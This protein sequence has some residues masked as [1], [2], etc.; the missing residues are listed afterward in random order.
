MRVPQHCPEADYLDFVAS[1]AQF[2]RH[3]LNARRRFY[4]DFRQRWPSLAQWFMA[5]LA[6]RAGRLPGEGF[7][8]ASFPVSHRARP[9]LTFLGLRGHAAFDYPWMLAV[10]RLRV[11]EQAGLL[12]LDLG[13]DALVEEAVAM[14]YHQGSARQAMSWCV[15]RIVLRHG[16]PDAA[17]ITEA[18]IAEALDAIRCFAEHPQ[19]STFYT[20][21]QQFRDGPAK[22]WITH[23]HQLQVVLYHRGQ[24]ATQ[25]SKLMPSWKPPLVLPTLMLAAA[26]RWLAARRLTDA[27]ST[28]A[29]LELA[30]RTFGMWLADNHPEISTFAAVT[31]EHCLDWIGHLAETPSETTRKPLGVMSRIQRIS[32]M[33]QFF[34]DTAVWQ[35]PDVPGHTLVGAGDAPKF[36]Q[37]VPRFI[38]E[39]ELEQLMPVIDQ[40][41]CPFQRAALLVA[42][43]SGARRDEIRRLPLDCMDRYPD[44]TARLRL[45][46]RKTYKERG[47]DDVHLG[48]GHDPRRDRLPVA[49]H[50]R[51]CPIPAPPSPFA[52]RVERRR[53]HPHP[54]CR[55]SNHRHRRPRSRR[56]AA[57][58][59]P[60]H[61]ARHRCRRT[62]YSANR[63]SAQP[64]DR[65]GRTRRA[66]L[67]TRQPTR[68]RRTAYRGPGGHQ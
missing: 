51:P 60:A 45:S 61:R 19:F 28:V 35:Y 13:T 55:T 48:R 62:R 18:H 3:Y 64:H 42:R 59:R 56:N 33:S 65:A 52:P 41:T 50:R 4:R 21:P 7:S 58:R 67:P 6:E 9:Y 66:S 29:K 30:V 25:P 17:A 68:P 1:Q 63:A 36:P 32:G 34:R 27:P 49:P 46:G 22:T 10:D 24:V 5:P 8:D 44:G 2:N 53:C 38:P 57:T 39:D 23:L 16:L 54:P 37:K 26:D 47:P 43:W 14:G 20:S 12:G 15:S 40:I 31:R 11:A